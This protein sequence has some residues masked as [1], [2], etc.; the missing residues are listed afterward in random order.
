M[1]DFSPHRLRVELA[2]ANI[3]Q[4]R[5]AHLL[6]TPPSTLSTWLNGAAPAPADLVKRIETALDLEPGSLAGPQPHAE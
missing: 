3:T 2:K 1:S 4:R 5:L 6:G